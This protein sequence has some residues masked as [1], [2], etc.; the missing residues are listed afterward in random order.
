MPEPAGQPGSAEAIAQA[1]GL[2]VEDIG[3]G[4]HP[5]SRFSAGVP[6]CLVPVASR[7]ALAR[8]KLCPQDWAAAFGDEGTSAYVY[9]DDPQGKGHSFRARMF[10]P[11]FGAYEDPATGSAAAAFAGAVMA[12][13]RP[14]DGDH[15][16]IIE[17]GF[18]MGRPSLITLG[19]EVE[20]GILQ[21]ASIGGHAVLVAQG[22]I[23]V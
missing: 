5:P 11:D 13:D 10:A 17:Q 7:A 3:F 4:A 1:L 9:C 14:K 20:R 16:L 2:A 21:A 18:E 19:L 22:V 15:T 6:Y 23:D 12:Y 8:I